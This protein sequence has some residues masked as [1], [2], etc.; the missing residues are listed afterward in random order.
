MQNVTVLVISE[1]GC[2]KSANGNAFLQIDDAF[3]T[4]SSPDSCTFVTS[5]K[6]N[7]VNGIKRHYIDTQG[8]GSSDGLDAG[9]IQQMVE[10]LKAWTLGVNAFFILLNIHSPRFNTDVQHMI[11][12]INDFFNN[13]EFWN[14]TGIIFTK[15]FPGYFNRETADADT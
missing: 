13:P 14:Q 4:N 12:L 8:F 6:N 11:R 7:V 15:C 3:E 2:G 10:F 9:Y 1:T 5:S